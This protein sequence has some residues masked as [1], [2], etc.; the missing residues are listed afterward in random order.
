MSPPGHLYGLI[1]SNNASD[2]SNDVDIASGQCRDIGDTA[3]LLL[4]VSITKRLDA[5]WSAGTGQGGLDAGT[6]AAD[7]AYHVWIIGR[8]DNSQV[9]A[10]FSTSAT[11]PTMPSGYT[12]KRR[13]GCVVTDGSSNL[14]AF[15][16]VGGWFQ[17]KGSFPQPVNNQSLTGGSAA[18]LYTLTGIPLGLKVEL[19]LLGNTSGG[20]GQGWCTL[21]DP[22]LGP[23]ADQTWGSFRADVANGVGAEVCRVWSNVSAQIYARLQTTATLNVWVRGWYDNRDTSV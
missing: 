22:D 3:D 18:T 21:S 19:D 5:A 4:G 14:R 15:R 20:T 17:Y 16:Q 13:V 2:V 10:L 9:D 1:L 8:S 12:R 6:K 7:T 23:P 11:N